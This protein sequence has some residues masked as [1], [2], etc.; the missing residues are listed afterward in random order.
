MLAI[1]ERSDVT[2]TPYD[3]ALSALVI[4][5]ETIHFA[6][7]NLGDRNDPKTETST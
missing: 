2:T 5:S 6:Y 3:A 1:R 7:A 4:A